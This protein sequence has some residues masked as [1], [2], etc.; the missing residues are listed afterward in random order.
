MSSLIALLAS[1][2]LTSVAQLTLR[3]ALVQL[4]PVSS[5]PTHPAALLST[6]GVQLAFGVA[7]YALS[8]L[9]WLIALARI[10]LGRAY[11]ALSLSYVLVHLGALWLPGAAE[12]TSVRPLLGIALIVIGVAL[13]GSDRPPVS[14]SLRNTL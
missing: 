1:I 9:A 2:G 6:A 4:P 12:S 5:W 11:A 3:Y 14:S 13:V 10:P 7:C 8:M